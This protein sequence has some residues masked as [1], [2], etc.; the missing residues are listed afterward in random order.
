MKYAICRQ[1]LLPVYQHLVIEADSVEDACQKAV[2]HDDWEDSE[3]DF[4]SS[5]RTTI[6]AVRP[7]SEGKKVENVASFLYGS[8]DAAKEEIDAVPAQFREDTPPSTVYIV[9]RSSDMVGTIVMP[10]AY[11]SQENAEQ[12]I[13]AD[14]EE[15]DTIRDDYEI[16]A[17]KVL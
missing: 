9:L 11:S 13:A 7:I 10:A 16:V 4:D 2:E 17:I 15:L 12:A 8:L 14:I 3:Q 5:R 6:E 1:Y